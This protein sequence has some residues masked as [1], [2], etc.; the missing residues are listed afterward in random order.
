MYAW[1]IQEAEAHFIELI[2]AC[3]AIGP[4]MVVKHGVE[5]AVLVPIAQWRQMQISAAPSL[6]QLLLEDTARGELMILPRGQAYR[7]RPA[8]LDIPA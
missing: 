1:S 7:R 2:E 6:K 3:S 8:T 4:Q 5:V